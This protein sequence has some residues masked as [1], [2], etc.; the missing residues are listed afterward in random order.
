MKIVFLNHFISGGGAE[1]VT[2]LLS[3]KMVEKGFDVSLMTNLFKPF[4]YD[5]DE[6][7]KKIPLFIT[8]KQS[9]SKLSL[10]HMIRNT[11]TM[12]KCEKPDVI[13]GVMPLMNFVAVVAAFGLKTKIIASDH[14]SFERKLPLHIKFIRNYVYRL[15]EHVTVL[16]QAD[17]NVIGNKLK[18]K[19][20]MPN[21]LAYPC[22]NDLGANRKRN[23][24]AVGRLDDWRVKG[25]DILIKAW[26]SI[27]DRYPDWVLDIAGGGRDN[28]IAEL[29]QI[30]KEFNVDKRLNLIGFRH[31]IDAVMRESSIFVLSSRVEGFGMVL[32]E[33]LSQGCACI[34]FDDRGRQR[35][36]ITSDKEGIII[37][38]KDPKLLAEKIELLIHEPALMHD[39]AQAG[40]KR[41]ESFNL[42][43]I[44]DKW[45]KLIKT[46]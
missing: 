39:M 34:S 40:V 4:A 27:A 25:F 43:A 6:R 17:Y 12:I 21:P 20:V 19:S 11:R 28:S 33:A 26:A 22:V 14:T 24:L 36:I 10:L 45:E 35:E 8:K 2:C 16:T 7:V 13:I 31:D 38:H 32:I 29:L 1:R 46:I 3:G 5:F 9:H 41:A 18:R 15:A 23:I 37:E 30:A 44:E 42:N